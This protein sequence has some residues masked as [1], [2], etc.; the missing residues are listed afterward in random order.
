MLPFWLE[1]LLS[2]LMIIFGLFYILRIIYTHKAARKILDSYSDLAEETD[3]EVKK[4]LN[5]LSDWP[6]LHG[7]MDGK[8][9][10]V[11]PNRGK[12][13][14]PAKT[15]FAVGTGIDLSE[16]IIIATSETQIPED[17]HGLD[18]QHLKNYKYKVYSEENYGDEFIEQ[19]FSKKVSRKIHDLIENNEENFRALII[20][21]GLAMYSNFD[22]E[23]DEEKILKNIKKTTEV[24]TEMEKNIS[25]VEE[26]KKSPRMLKIGEGTSSTLIKGVLPLLLFVIAGYLFYQ[27]LDDFS[28]LFMNAAMVFAVIGILK[29]Y[30]LAY[31]LRKY[32]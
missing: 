15:I 1:I 13:K 19:L 27:V 10:Y 17:S 12:R 6:N 20:E 5:I 7:K 11:H 30:V 31:T 18:A 16:D 26:G 21:P 4:S 25:K 32:Q 29:S 24:V 28:F 9:V 23:L 2:F 8:E 3:L 22:I 14:S